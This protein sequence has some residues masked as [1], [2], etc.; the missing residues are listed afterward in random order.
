MEFCYNQTVNATSKKT[1]FEAVY[2]YTTTVEITESRQVQDED[3]LL[4]RMKEV[5]EALQAEMTWAQERM[6]ELADQYRRSA[7]EVGVGDFVYL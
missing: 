5:H 6:S 2:G 3:G 1:R 7:S 4:E